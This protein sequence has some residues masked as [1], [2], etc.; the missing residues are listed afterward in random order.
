[1]QQK[2]T[3]REQGDGCQRVVVRED[4]WYKNKQKKK[5]QVENLINW[6]E[7]ISALVM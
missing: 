7:N 1:M 6:P 2:Q 3:H 5:N 4:W